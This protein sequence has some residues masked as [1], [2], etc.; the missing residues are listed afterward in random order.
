MNK[1]SFSDSAQFRYAR[2]LSITFPGAT[3]ALDTDMTVH[4]RPAR[5]SCYSL[6]NHI[7]AKA[8][9]YEERTV[10]ETARFNH[11]SEWELLKREGTMKP[12]SDSVDLVFS[13]P[14][15]DSECRFTKQ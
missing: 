13:I 8:K 5:K 15:H 3:A 2:V 11:G 4:Q 12:R 7:Q 6:Q 14:R 10:F 1:E 9:F